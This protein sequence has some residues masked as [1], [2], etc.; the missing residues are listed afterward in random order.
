[1][2]NCT[3]QPQ[4]TYTGAGCYK[5]AILDL[6]NEGRK[7]IILISDAVTQAQG[8]LAMLEAEL[9]TQGLRFSTVLASS[10]SSFDEALELARK[11]APELPDCFISFGVDF[12]NFVAKMMWAYYEN[13]QLDIE[14]LHTN[15]ADAMQG[16]APTI[17]TG[18]KATLLAIPG[19]YML[20]G[21]YGPYVMLPDREGKLKAFIDP[22]LLPDRLAVDPCLLVTVDAAILAADGFDAFTH[23][24]E[25]FVADGEDETVKLHCLAGM[26]DVFRYLPTL[27]KN[28]DD[29]RAKTKVINGFMHAGVVFSNLFSGITHSMTTALQAKFGIAH[30]VANA[31]TLPHAIEFL[32]Q[33]NSVVRQRY[34]HAAR[35]LGLEGDSEEELVMKLIAAIQD[36]KEVIGIPANIKALGVD[37]VRYLLSVDAMAHTAASYQSTQYSPV[38][39]DISGFRRILASAYDE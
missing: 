21:E 32:M 7:N 34:A 29:I 39:A 4:K 11:A 33:S 38:P 5:K 10:A 1:M 19:A 20:G 12:I 31:M 6:K 16:L 25:C 15:F 36:F 17:V 23:C 35:H 27:V 37:S 9:A 28:Q 30:G 26:A 22:A 8:K 14:R 2:F 18:R 24:V 13:P 3:I